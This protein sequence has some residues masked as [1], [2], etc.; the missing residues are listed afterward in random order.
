[1]ARTMTKLRQV[2]NLKNGQGIRYLLDAAK[3]IFNNPIFTIDMNHKLIALTDCAVDDPVWNELATTGTFSAKTLELLAKECFME[4]IA[5]ADKNV[6]IRSDQIKYARMAGYFFNRENI[7]AGLVVMS[8]YDACFDDESQAAFELFATKISS[9]IRNDEY[10]TTLGRAFHEDIITG[11]LN[12]TITN[13]PVYT[14][15]V[16]VLYDGF[17]DFIHVAVV[18]VSRNGT[19]QNKLEYLKELLI[20][21]NR[22]YKY[23]VYSDHIIIVM[24]SKF[25]YFHEGLFFDK[26]LGAFKKNNLFVGVSDHF[27]NLYKLRNHYDE[28]VTA[29]KTGINNV[30]R[31]FL[32]N[33]NH[34]SSDS[35][36]R[37]N[38][39]SVIPAPFGLSISTN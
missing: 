34:V 14:P 30:Q 2:K 5:N 13:S 32:Y 27:E 24:S 17:E 15:Q 25:Q 6:I 10:F 4:K 39:Y 23:A 11:L 31:V 18:D 8:E 3:T 19:Q 28:A 29:L 16:Q 7:K 1:M 37:E 21:K 26:H 36:R 20:S 33:N 9:E 12:R 35:S 22:S 38:A